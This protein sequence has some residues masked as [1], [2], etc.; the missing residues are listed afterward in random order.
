MWISFL[1]GVALIYWRPSAT[2]RNLMITGRNTSHKVPPQRKYL[3]TAFT[4][5]LRKQINYTVAL[6]ET[7]R[8]FILHLY[9]LNVFKPTGG[10]PVIRVYTAWDLFH[11]CTRGRRH[12][13]HSFRPHQEFMTCNVQNQYTISPFSS[14]I[15]EFLVQ[16]CRDHRTRSPFQQL[17]NGF[18]PRFIL[19]KRSCPECARSLRGRTA[20]IPSRPSSSLPMI[21]MY[22]VGKSQM[23][24]KSRMSETSTIF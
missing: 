17:S 1:P 22:A 23:C 9:V 18:Q 16:I 2:H 10:S 19:I 13:C 5:A 20:V 12:Y 24:V 8:M 7:Y 15:R 21:R 11:A 4:V 6:S 14:R 3:I